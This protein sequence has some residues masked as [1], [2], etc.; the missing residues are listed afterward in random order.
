MI[1]K[2]CLESSCVKEP[3]ELVM[4]LSGTSGLWIFSK[5]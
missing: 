1:A 3:I 5:L 2:R 4:G